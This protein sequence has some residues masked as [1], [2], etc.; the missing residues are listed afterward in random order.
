MVMR[1]AVAM[2]FLV[3]SVSGFAPPAWSPTS[4]A[5]LRLGASRA[6]KSPL[7]AAQS[8]GRRPHFVSVRCQSG[9]NDDERKPHKSVSVT[10]SGTRVCIIGGG[11]GGLYT[12]IQLAKLLPLQSEEYRAKVFSAGGPLL[13]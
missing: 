13:I 11:F 6:Q 2:G 5:S 9:K 10:G 12:A 1:T 4:R 8:L 3:L 7:Q